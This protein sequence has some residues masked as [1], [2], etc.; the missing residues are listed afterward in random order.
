MSE[1]VFDT[2]V[3]SNN[4]APIFGK[5]GVRILAGELLDGFENSRRDFLKNRIG[6]E[7]DLLSKSGLIKSLRFN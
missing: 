2:S 1:V 6:D 4:H 7:L 3:E 5:L